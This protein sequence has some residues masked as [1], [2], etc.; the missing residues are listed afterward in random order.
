MSEAPPPEALRG[1][2]SGFTPWCRTLRGDQAWLLEV[3]GGVQ[4]LATWR[5]L[6]ERHAR[7]GLW[8]VLLGSVPDLIVDQ[9]TW[10]VQIL[11]DDRPGIARL[12]E[13][14]PAPDLFVRWLGDPAAD[15]YL[16]DVPRHLAKLQADEVAIRDRLD[17][18]P[19]DVA[20][21]SL[22]GETVHIV[23]VPAAGGWEVP[24]LLAWSG[25]EKEGHGGPEHVAVLHFWRES[26]GAELIGL[27]LESLE[28]LVER[29]P[30]DARGAFELAM[31]HYA[32]CPELMD[33]L[34]PAIGALAATLLGRHWYFDWK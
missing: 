27:G 7:T 15:A 19:D 20:L 13:V 3:P 30:T 12:S 6:R 26:Y 28:L 23:L 31:Q 33:N 32:Y 16:S 10:R 29:P 34:A 24:A 21:R 22:Q 8:P 5:A 2:P 9:L 4:A 11:A 14:T 1:L 17:T 18:R 25:A